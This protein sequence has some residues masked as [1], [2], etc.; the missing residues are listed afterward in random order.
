LSPPDC[1]RPPIAPLFVSPTLSVVPNSF[2]PSLQPHYRAFF[3]TM[4]SADFSSALASEISPSKVQYLSQRAARLYLTRLGW[5]SGFAVLRQLTARAR[6]LCTVRV[7]AVVGLPAASFSFTSRLRLA[8]WLRLV[9][10]PPLSTFQLNRYC[11]CRAHKAP[12][13][14]GGYRQPALAPCRGARGPKVRESDPTPAKP[15]LLVD[16]FRAACE[17]STRFPDRSLGFKRR[18]FQGRNPVRQ[19][20]RRRFP[21]PE[22]RAR[23]SPQPP[24]GTRG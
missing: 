11:P 14:P 6:P 13:S 22:L 10:S 20:R 17:H 15:C 18:P 1:L 12:G 4:T 24:P 8:V 2:R 5:T 21:N 3:A 16:P 7:P 19:G 23:V 9:P